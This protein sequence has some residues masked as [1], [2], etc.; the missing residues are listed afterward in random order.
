MTS[1]VPLIAA[2]LLGLWVVGFGVGYLCTVFKRS[3][4]SI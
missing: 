4:E 1:N 2:A 3:I